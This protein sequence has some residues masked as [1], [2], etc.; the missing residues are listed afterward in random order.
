MHCINRHYK[1]QFISGLFTINT[2]QERNS[3]AICHIWRMCS[4]KNADRVVDI[5]RYKDMT[6]RISEFIQY[7]EASGAASNTRT[8]YERDIRLLIRQLERDGVRELSDI[9]SAELMQYIDE[10]SAEGKSAATISRTIASVRK[11][12]A[13]THG[14]G[15]TFSDPSELLTTPKVIKKAPVILSEKEIKRVITSI[16][17][18]TPKGLRDKTMLELIMAIGISVSEI[19]ELS[20]DDVD[21]NAQTILLGG[22]KRRVNISR[23][24]TDSLRAY[25]EVR[26]KMLNGRKD[27]GAFFL[28]YVG[29]K[30][31]RQGMWKTIR[32]CG[33]NAGM[34][35]ITPQTLRHSFAVSAL[36]HGKDAVS[37]QK[38]LGHA[39]KV[40]VTEYQNIASAEL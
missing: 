24:T 7:I 32:E 11:F 12:F 26:D 9:S 16:D 13:F 34:D 8:A 6:D 1:I 3:A 39:T 15:Y 27:C 4:C 38:M 17:T 23:K 19:V 21:L 31:S 37:I 10:L 33:L 35:N 29:K 5:G 18:S 25:T 20:C 2:L 36:R 22:D 30:M 14:R 40:G 28:S